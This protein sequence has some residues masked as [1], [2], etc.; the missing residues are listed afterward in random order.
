MSGYSDRELA[1]A[2]YDVRDRVTRIEE[3][4]NR[5]E[6]IEVKANEA[7]DKASSALLK[8]QENEKRLDRVE[9]NIKWAWGFMI[10]FGLSVITV[11]VNVLL[12]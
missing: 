10:T 7:D 4:L 12:K 3:K 1:D 5:T 6:K 8:T 2:I 11:L 9:N